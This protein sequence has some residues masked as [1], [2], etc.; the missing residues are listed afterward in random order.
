MRFEQRNRK[1]LFAKGDCRGLS[2]LQGVGMYN[3]QDSES[4]FTWE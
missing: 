1:G 3:V 4:R 2:S